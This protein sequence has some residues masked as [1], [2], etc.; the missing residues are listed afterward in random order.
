MK[1]EFNK[2]NKVELSCKKEER[3][4]ILA[5][6]INASSFIIQDLRDTISF[7]ETVKNE[8]KYLKEKKLIN[9]IIKKYNSIIDK[10]FVKISETIEKMEK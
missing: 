3:D 2:N 4:N 8:K 7:L 1:K 9:R 10:E 5:E 6:Q